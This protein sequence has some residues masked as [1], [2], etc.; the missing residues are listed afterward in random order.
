MGVFLFFL[1]GYFWVGI[2]LR[3][4]IGGGRSVILERS[5]GYISLLMN[6]GPSINS[7]SPHDPVLSQLPLLFQPDEAGNT[8]TLI[9]GVSPPTVTF[10][11]WQS[12]TFTCVRWRVRWRVRKMK[13]FPAVGR[14]HAWVHLSSEGHEPYVGVSSDAGGLC[15]L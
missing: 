11:N 8:H 10:W 5:D 13:G 14:P 12:D 4:Q 1:S 2:T 9:T 15:W 3:F 6:D 7:D